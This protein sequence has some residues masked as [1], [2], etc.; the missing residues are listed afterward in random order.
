M[1]LSAEPEPVNSSRLANSDR[2][3]SA[4]VRPRPDTCWLAPRVTVST[5]MTAPASDA[6]D[7]GRQQPDQQR[8]GQV[9]RREPGERARVHRA[10]DAQVE[11]AGTLGD[12]SRRWCRRRAAWRSAAWRRGGRRA[13]SC[14][15]RLHGCADPSIRSSGGRL[16]LIRRRGRRGLT[17]RCRT[18][19]RPDRHQQQHAL[20]ARRPSGT[21]CPA[22]ARP[23]WRPRQVAQQQPGQQHARHRQPAQHRDHDAGVAE[24]GREPDVS[25]CW[26]PATSLTPAMPAMAPLTSAT[27]SSVRSTSHARE[28]GRMRG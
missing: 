6:H 18:A 17:R 10:F 9:R 19:S 21:G 15:R 3:I 27:R 1:R 14:R 26:M 12:R 7:D 13:S 5:P 8:A 28:P 20:D 24:P 4:M 16:R 11:D 2:P 25:R 22:P 23:S